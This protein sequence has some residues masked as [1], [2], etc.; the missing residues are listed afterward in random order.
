[1]TRFN[2]P[3]PTGKDCRRAAT[4]RL[5]K[6]VYLDAYL[7]A[8]RLFSDCVLC[9]RIWSKARRVNRDRSLTSLQKYPI[10]EWKRSSADN[11]CVRELCSTTPDTRASSRNERPLLTAP[12]LFPSLPPSFFPSFQADKHECLQPTARRVTQ[13]RHDARLQRWATQA[14]RL[15]PREQPVQTMSGGNASTRALTSSR[16]FVGFFPSHIPEMWECE[17]RGNEIRRQW[18]EKETLVVSTSQGL[19]R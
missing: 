11:R 9:S 1:M 14:L 8:V 16:Q 13:Q 6:C 3:Q 4:Q 15:P 18:A 7:Q 10:F 5:S 2:V 19:W 12:S 17:E